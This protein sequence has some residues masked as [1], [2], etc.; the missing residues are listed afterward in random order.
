M[1]IKRR[2]AGPEV[3]RAAKARAD[4][5][6]AQARERGETLLRGHALEEA[7]REAGFR[8]WNTLSGRAVL[9]VPVTVRFFDPTALTAPDAIERLLYS[10]TLTRMRED[11]PM[12][13]HLWGTHTL[14]VADPARQADAVSAA[15]AWIALGTPLRP[16][17]PEALRAL[18][19]E[20][21]DATN[22]DGEQWIAARETRAVVFPA[23]RLGTDADALLA[24]CRAM[25]LHL[26]LVCAPDR[27]ADLSPGVFEAL[28]SAVFDDPGGLVTAAHT[29]QAWGPFLRQDPQDASAWI[30]ARA[31][32][33][34]LRAS[35]GD[36]FVVWSERAGAATRIVGDNLVEIL[37]HRHLARQHAH[38]L[39]IAA[40]GFQ[41]WS[42]VPGAPAD[43][44]TAL[45]GAPGWF[46]KSRPFAPLPGEI[47]VLRTEA[48][49]HEEALFFAQQALPDA[50]QSAVLTVRAGAY[51]RLRS[52][53]AWTEMMG[54]GLFGRRVR[55]GPAFADAER[56]A[57]RSEAPFEAP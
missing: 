1:D 10:R 33:R 35:P 46:A 20:R 21:E 3:V 40:K 12:E 2:D 57:R 41:D 22:Q 49:S 8:D 29:T 4:A 53:D 23:E 18:L 37:L 16:E 28:R 55:V 9:S 5:L 14:L 38:R 56:A 27:I 47:P 54:P 42:D 24:H 36:V 26:L 6:M 48:R 11:E 17:T 15:L 30:G 31:R 44:G 25:G 51:P 43:L 32:K 13:P 50:A 39:R 52:Y 19:A 7:A 45:P 34:V